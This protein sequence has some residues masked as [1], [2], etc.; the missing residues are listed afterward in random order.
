LRPVAYKCGK[1]LG[2]A[3]HVMNSMTKAAVWFL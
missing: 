2:A 1:P 3:G